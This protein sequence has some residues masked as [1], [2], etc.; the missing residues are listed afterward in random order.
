MR[1]KAGIALITAILAYTGLWLFLGS[2]HAHHRGM[3]PHRNHAQHSC[4]DSVKT[5]QSNN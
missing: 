3:H 2:A 4:A 5:N 1:R